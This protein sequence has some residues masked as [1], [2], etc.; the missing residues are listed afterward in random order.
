[1]RHSTRLLLIHEDG[2][3]SVPGPLSEQVK[4]R[5]VDKTFAAAVKFNGQ[6]TQELILEKESKL[7]A[8]VISNGLQPEEGYLLA[9][10]NDPGRTKPFMRV[11]P[12]SLP[13]GVF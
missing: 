10:Y 2:C 13:H 11:S 5:A 7:R 3:F 4:L 1:M 12:S 8:A 9:R 6:T